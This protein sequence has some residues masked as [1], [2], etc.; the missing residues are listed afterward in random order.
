[1]SDINT[2]LNAITGKIQQLQQQAAQLDQMRGNTSQPTQTALPNV[3]PTTTYPKA[4]R[5]DTAED[6][7]NNP[8]WR[9]E[10]EQEFIMS[11][12]GKKADYYREVLFME[13][14]ENQTGKSSAMLQGLRQQQYQQQRTTYPKAEPIQEQQAAPAKGKGKK[15]AVENE[16]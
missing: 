4:V 14:V 9:L 15:E 2:D 7:L 5:M 11:D 16:S 6:I 10:L 1:M 12:M 3:Q 8:Q 13:F